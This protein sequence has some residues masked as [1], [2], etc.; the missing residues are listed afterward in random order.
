MNAPRTTVI[1]IPEWP[2]DVCVVQTGTGADCSAP[3]FFYFRLLIIIPQFLLTHW[4]PP[5]RCTKALSRQHIMSSLV[6]ELGHKLKLSTWLVE[7]WELRTVEFH[8][9]GLIGTA[10]HTN[11]REVRIIGLFLWKYGTLAV[12]SS[13]FTIYSMYLRLNLSTTPDLE[14]L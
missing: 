13:A 7:E 5:K 11:M 3:P 9:S 2:W 4:R 1:F 12:L 14:V 10:S 8:L 6:S